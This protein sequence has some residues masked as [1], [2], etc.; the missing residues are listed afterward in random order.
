[1]KMKMIVLRET[2][3]PKNEF[4]LAGARDA[5]RRHRFGLWA[6]MAPSRS[7]S[8]PLDTFAPY[9][10]WPQAAG[11][12]ESSGR[13]LVLRPLLTSEWRACYERTHP[14]WGIARWKGVRGG[15]IGKSI[16]V[17]VWSG[18]HRRPKISQPSA[19]RHFS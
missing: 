17:Q 13:Q 3:H 9:D 5:G 4:E 16:V 6:A 14:G 1:M 7:G 2:K 8:S 12:E 19:F 15:S 10:P 18:A 11:R